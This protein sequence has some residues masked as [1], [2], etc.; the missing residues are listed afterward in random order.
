MVSQ[1]DIDIIKCSLPKEIPVMPGTMKMHQLILIEPG[2][3]HFRDVSC[4]CSNGVKGQCECFQKNTYFT[5]NKAKRFKP[6]P[7]SSSKLLYRDIYSSCDE[8]SETSD[9]DYNKLPDAGDP[10]ELE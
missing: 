4:Y 1:D 8:S 2:I 9:D 5:K 6:G 3:I 7:S 10:D